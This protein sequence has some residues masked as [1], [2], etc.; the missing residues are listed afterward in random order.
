MDYMFVSPPE[1]YIE[2]LTPMGWYYTVGAL[3]AN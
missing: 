3:K 2:N 1:L